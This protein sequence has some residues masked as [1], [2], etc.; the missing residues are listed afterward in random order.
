MK[1]NPFLLAPLC[2][3]LAAAVLLLARVTSAPGASVARPALVAP[4]PAATAP[5]HRASKLIETIER[6]A[7]TRLNGFLTRGGHSAVTTVTAVRPAIQRDASRLSRWIAGQ[8]GDARTDVTRSAG[9]ARTRAS[10]AK[11]GLARL[12]ARLQDGRRQ[13]GALLQSSLRRAGTRLQDGLRASAR[14]VTG[15]MR[16]APWNR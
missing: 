5:A 11:I 14:A 2:L 1:P 4:R 8:A 7:G 6:E 15:I 13:S 3:A 16:T 10:I 9:A 12:G